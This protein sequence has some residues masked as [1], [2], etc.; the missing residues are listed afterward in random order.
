MNRQEPQIIEIPR[1][2]PRSV[3]QRD[4]FLGC[5]FVQTVNGDKAIFWEI[6]KSVSFIPAY[7][8]ILTYATIR[9]KP[10]S[11]LELMGG[12]MNWKLIL[13]LAV[14]GIAM[15]LG[16]VFFVSSLV[17][18][19]LWPIVFLLSAYVIA[20]HC[21]RLRFLNGLIVGL[22]DSLLKTTVHM[23]FFNSYVARHSGEIA[24]IRQ[25]TS[26]ISPRQLILLSSP[27]WGLVFGTVIGLL[28]ML[29]GMFMKPSERGKAAL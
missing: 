16:T 28:A 15:G 10:S 27:V 12:M 1:L 17:E 24:M 6:V 26:A 25:M 14:F 8:A 22:L 9:T 23:V 5:G 29:V 19:I 11:L 4:H 21:A 2:I 3:L 20:K 13:Q 18:L 7:S